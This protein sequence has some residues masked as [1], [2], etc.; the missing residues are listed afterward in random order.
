VSDTGVGLPADFEARRSDS[1]GLQLISDLA[2]QLGG[3]LEIGPGPA[4]VFTITFP[5]HHVSLSPDAA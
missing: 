1:L 3:T 5:V 2:G 4:A